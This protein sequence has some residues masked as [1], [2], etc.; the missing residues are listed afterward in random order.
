MLNDRAQRLLKTLVERYIADG[1]PVG[2][3]TLTQLSGLDISPASVRNVMAELED[4]GLVASP[5]TSAGRVPTARGY[6][7]F[8]DK[9]LTMHPLEQQALRQVESGIHPDSPLRMAAAASQLLSDLTHFAGVVIT[10]QRADAAFRQIEFLSLSEKRILLILVTPLGDVQNHLLVTDRDYTPG[11]LIETANYLNHHYAGQSL[12]HI[13]RDLEQELASLQGH[14]ARLM[15]AAIHASKE[16]TSQDDIVVSGEKR[17]LSVE[18]LSSDL[19]SLRRLFDMFEHK[20][21]LLH[22]LNI[23][24]Q[25]QGVSLF[26]GEESGLSPLDG[27]TVVTAPY[28]FDG[29]R[30]G[31]LGVVGPT[32]MNYERVIPIVDITAR[33]VSSALSSPLSG[34]DAPSSH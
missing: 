19:A 34:S 8:V 13:T 32:R 33:L 26:I 22:L 7:V 16:A 10:P 24:R 6:R 14:I 30:V 5:H 18:E 31:T 25:A 1:Q 9:L 15:T 20:T 23:S 21:E 2:S 3:R 4:M 11:E 29:T 27:C 17:L 28:T 12:E